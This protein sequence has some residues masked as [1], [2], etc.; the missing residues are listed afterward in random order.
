MHHNADR[1][2]LPRLHGKA[3]VMY[4][5]ANAGRVAG[6]VS[7]VTKW[8]RMEKSKFLLNSIRHRHVD[9]TPSPNFCLYDY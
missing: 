7:Q 4:A 9:G 6:T 8:N 3:L 2:L 5:R 1:N